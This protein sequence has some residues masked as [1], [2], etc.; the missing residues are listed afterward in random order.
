MNVTG[1]TYKDCKLGARAVFID[2]SDVG[3]KPTEAPGAM[4]ISNSSFENCTA[5]VQTD[6]GVMQL[7]DDCKIV[8]GIMA[9]R[10]IGGVF[11]I[12]DCSI[13]DAASTGITVLQKGAVTLANTTI[14]GCGL[15]GIVMTSGTLTMTGGSITNSIDVGAFL[16]RECIAATFNG[17]TFKDN[18]SFTVASQAE[19]ALVTISRS[20]FSG[21]DYGIQVTAK[22]TLTRVGIDGCA[23]SDLGQH[24]IY[25]SGKVHVKYKNCDFG[26]LAEE[27]QVASRQ[28]AIVEKI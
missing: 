25:A 5:S 7:R 8:G 18:I 19:N 27:K 28:A 21:S 2:E 17:V 9:V 13:S 24:A 3:E 22:E 20:R 15:N 23:F 16:D 26:T 12:E 11:G 6:Y 4:T 10:I 14:N 1:C